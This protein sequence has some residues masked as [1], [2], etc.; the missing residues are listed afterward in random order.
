MVLQVSCQEII[1][2]FY[3]SDLP[4]HYIFS[5]PKFLSSLLAIQPFEIAAEQDLD[6]TFQLPKTTYI[7][8]DEVA[9][10]LREILKRLEVICL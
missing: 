3:H 2:L 10:T 9:L 1:N 8:G 6:K 7:G 5:V 4:F